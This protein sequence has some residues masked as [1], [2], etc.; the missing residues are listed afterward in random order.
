VADEDTIADVLLA[1]EEAREQGRPL[2]AEE[3]CRDCPELVV[4]VRERIRLLEKTAWMS[5]TAPAPQ[6]PRTL[7]ER[8]VLEQLLG[9]GGFSQVWRA[10]DLQLHRHVAV[11]VPLP[12]RT[13]TS[14][15]IEEV[16]VE[17]RQIARLKHVNIITLHDVVKEGAGYFL[18][19][20]LIEGETLADRLRRGPMPPAEAVKVLAEV[21]RAI[22]YA[23]GQGVVHRDLKPANI[24]LDKSGRPHVGDFG[25]A[26][27]A[28]ELAD[29]SDQR[30]TLAYSSPEQLEGQPLDGR[31]DIWSLGVILYEMLTGRPP[32]ADDNPVRLKQAI[33]AGKVPDAPGV[34]A[35]L[36]GVCRRCLTA[37]AADRIQTGNKL[38][39]AVESAT[40]KTSSR[41]W[42]V[43]SSCLFS[44]LL[45][46][47]MWMFWP[48]TNADENNTPI[49][50]KPDDPV[51]PTT[52]TPIPPP[53]DDSARVLRGH[54]GAVRS[55]ALS[56]DGTL[57]G[58]GGDDGKLRLWPTEGEPLTLDHDSAVTAV[59]IGRR[60]HTALTGTASG[61]VTI[62]GLPLR[63]DEER[64]AS[65][66]WRLSPPLVGPRIPIET[67]P[68]P[69]PTAPWKVRTFPAQV[70]GIK[71][72]AMSPNR[73][74]V[75]WAGAEKLEVWAVG[76]TQPLTIARTPGE[77]IHHFD[78]WG[79]GELYMA[80]GFAAERRVTVRTCL[81][82]EVND[83]WTASV[84]S[85]GKNLEL[86]TDVQGF[87]TS[88]DRATVLVTQSHAVR[89]FTK[90]AKAGE[91]ALA[92][93]YESP[94]LVLN[95]S[96]KVREDRAVTVGRD[97]TLRFW[98][99]SNQSEV[100]T[101]HGHAKPIT[102]LAADGKGEV[103]AT[104]SEDGTVRVWKTP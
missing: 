54:V 81:L 96:L 92:G 50:V 23:H 21:A 75:A 91:L 46:V 55:V 51:T 20:D 76:G 63:T 88:A 93:S 42:L 80:F 85:P 57:I 95:A 44:A 30:G 33:L 66:L 28:T 103:V 35:A 68:L 62:W 17:A 70:G 15:Q 34:P 45:L 65:E 2:T 104:A 89:V 94:K 86:F 11:K 61:T 22:D 79:D 10:Y 56:W 47:L 102:A 24:L 40:I 64:V 71:S 77:A 39:T 52:P 73:R 27:P 99:L 3:L 48:K 58:S 100:A 36:M 18:V 78:F 25:L 38:A 97:H 31:S 32:F 74:F 72:V 14:N 84:T 8:Y 16:L 59:R 19:T 101:L 90:T 7:A 49:A 13:R 5:G 37:N 41:R 12:S 53:R 67:L 98:L 6:P 1:W 29:G 82:S 4:V 83:R 9:S 43:I 87:T 60:G 26:R 69:T